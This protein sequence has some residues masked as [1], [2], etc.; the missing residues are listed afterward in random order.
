[1]DKVQEGEYMSVEPIVRFL[2]SAGIRMLTEV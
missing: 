1:M 2:V